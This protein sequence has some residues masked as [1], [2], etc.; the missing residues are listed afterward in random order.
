MRLVLLA[1]SSDQRLYE[2]KM[3]ATLGAAM[4]Y[5]EERLQLA[6]HGVHL[7][8]EPLLLPL[9]AS[10]RALAQLHA[11][12]EL[13]AR[14]RERGDHLILLAGASPCVDEARLVL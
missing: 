13:V 1:G 5:A 3:L 12:S 4:Q 2:A 10:D 11:L 8:E 9:N 14:E 7:E 6:A